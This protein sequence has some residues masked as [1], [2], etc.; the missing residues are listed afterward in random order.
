V[1]Q[2]R[3]A[4]EPKAL[5]EY[6][7]SAIAPLLKESDAV[8][9]WKSKERESL[10]ERVKVPCRQEQWKPAKEVYAGRDWTDDD[11]LERAYGTRQDCAF[12]VAP[13]A[14]EAS[15][16]RF[17]LLARWLGVGWSPKVVPLI[18]ETNVSGT[19]K[20]S[21]WRG[22]RFPIANPPTR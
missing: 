3:E 12:L 8:M 2:Q 16:K 20:G 10:S 22:S 1:A 7:L 14:D 5:W 4:A 13:P 11:F 15:R 17:E 9:D 19:R 18:N 21:Q 6:L